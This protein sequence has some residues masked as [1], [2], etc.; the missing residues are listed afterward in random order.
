[1]AEKIS[2]CNQ[3]SCKVP[4]CNSYVL[5]LADVFEWPLIGK[6]RH[7]CYVCGGMIAKTANMSEMV[8]AKSRHYQTCKLY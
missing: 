8:T 6:P 7:F 3:L 1:M 5:V 4:G 2:G